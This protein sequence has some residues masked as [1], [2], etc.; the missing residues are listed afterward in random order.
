MLTSIKPLAHVFLD[1]KFHPAS[2][3]NGHWCEDIFVKNRA[4][5]D[6]ARSVCK[7]WNIL[8]FLVI[9]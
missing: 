3:V 5:D 8:E 2:G 6:G 4:I 7:N 1:S 9:L